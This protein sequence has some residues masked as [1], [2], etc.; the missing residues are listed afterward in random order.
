[1]Q[2]MNQSLFQLVKQKILSRE[3]ALNYSQ[4]PDE[5][6]KTFSLAAEKKT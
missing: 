1:M 6:A 3:D 5:L 2:T 4:V